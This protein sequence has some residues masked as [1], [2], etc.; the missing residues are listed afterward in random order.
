M[1]NVTSLHF[2]RQRATQETVLLTKLDIEKF[3]QGQLGKFNFNSLA[4]RTR[5]KRCPWGRDKTGNLLGDQGLLRTHKWLLAYP[6]APICNPFILP[7]NCHS[8]VH[9]PTPQTTFKVTGIT[10]FP[11][12]ILHY[13]DISISLS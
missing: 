2:N 11:V 5:D 1:N 3:R 13:F 6:S 9:F 10:I 12:L 8:S 4:L 7:S